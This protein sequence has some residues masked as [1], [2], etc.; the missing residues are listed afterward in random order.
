MSVLSTVVSQ[1]SH[2]V[3]LVAGVAVGQVPAVTKFIAGKI[4]AAKAKVVAA[5]AVAAADVKAEVKK[6]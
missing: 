5:E 6:V 2:P 1:V 4:A 3:A